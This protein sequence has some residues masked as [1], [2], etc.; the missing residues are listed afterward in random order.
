MTHKADLHT[1]LDYARAWIRGRTEH[2]PVVGIVLGSGMG[3]VAD[4]LRDPVSIPCQQ[5]P[6]FPVPTVPGH[7]GR[8]VL[9]RMGEVP[10]AVLQGR[11]HLYEGA[12][13]DDVVFGVRLL[14]WAGVKA[15]LV[16]NAA[17]AVNPD[18]APGELVRISDHLNLTGVNPL[19]GFNDDRVGTRFPDMGQAYD[20]ALGALLDACAT[21]L[22]SPLRSGVYA[23][24]LG[25]S[26]E[27]PAEVRMLRTMG[28]D[29][30][31]MSTVLEVIAARHAGV[32]VAGV[33]LVAN[34]A[35]GLSAEPLSHAEV[36]ATGAA[37]GKRLAA[38]A[39]AW[40][41]EAGR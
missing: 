7:E 18:L 19:A 17:G 11:V 21:R 5:V 34:R 35:A 25:P 37:A 16:T 40:A 23:G 10:V 20:P 6:E 29:L 27:T 8:L 41:A 9:G 13:P 39:A 4:A 33:S 2:R 1:R 38:L 12:S 24:V 3:A 15:L 36:L 22:G 32:R 30:V 31:G 28:A 26:Y 14:A